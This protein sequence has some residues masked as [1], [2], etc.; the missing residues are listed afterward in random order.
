MAEPADSLVGRPYLK[1][2]FFP[3]FLT[4][5]I[6]GA[7][8]EMADWE[9]GTLNGLDKTKVSP[10]LRRSFPTPW[11]PLTGGLMSGRMMF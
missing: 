10:S 7:T 5:S 1:I 11:C 4:I 2:D 3:T 8:G 6:Y 9:T